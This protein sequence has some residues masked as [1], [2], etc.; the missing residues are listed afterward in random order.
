[1][2]RKMQISSEDVISKLKDDGDFDRLRLKIIRKLKDNEDLRNSI[3][4]LVK[5]STALNRP[6]A[7]NMK[8]RQLSDA[9]HEEV[10]YVLELASLCQCLLAYGHLKS[11]SLLVHWGQI[12]SQISDNLWEII[13]SADGMKSEIT[14]TVQSVY[15]KLLNPKGKES[16][17]SAPPKLSPI[18]VEAQNNGSVMI[19]ADQTNHKVAD[20]EPSEPPGF[21]LTYNQQ[22]GLHDEQ[23]EKQLQIVMPDERAHEEQ[24][25]EVRQVK[26]SMELDDADQSVP[27]GFLTIAES[28]QQCDNSDDDPDL[29]PGFG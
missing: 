23:H 1:M 18:P 3:A 9:I 11:F 10:G 29:P 5:Q 28:N 6:G 25:E 24:K 22:N 2:E 27:P 21:S 8:P 19:M 20:L 17:S 16:E 15:N 7:E 14:D 26:D 13:R 4:S 12:M